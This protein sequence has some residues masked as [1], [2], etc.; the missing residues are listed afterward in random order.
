MAYF[1]KQ[2]RANLEK[3]LSLVPPRWRFSAAETERLLSV[4]QE[5]IWYAVRAINSED[6][7]REPDIFDEAVTCVC[8]YMKEAGA[9]VTQRYRDRMVRFLFFFS[10]LEAGVPEN[11]ALTLTYEIV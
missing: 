11:Q 2:F 1:N 6:C 3:A 5:I 10:Q 9:R 4:G 7:E 8:H